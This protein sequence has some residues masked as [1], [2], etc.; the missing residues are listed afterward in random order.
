[1]YYV[2]QK[3]KI[4]NNLKIYSKDIFKIFYIEYIILTTMD[5]KRNS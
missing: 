1:M 3:Y 4:R 2:L 5:I